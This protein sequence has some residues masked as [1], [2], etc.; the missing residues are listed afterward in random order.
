M[1]ARG[2]MTLGPCFVS[3][4]Q[5]P[6]GGKMAGKKKAAPVVTDPKA[7]QDLEHVVAGNPEAP[8]V[9][10]EEEAKDPMY[11]KVRI[12]VP[13]E[14]KIGRKV[15]PVGTHVVERHQLETILEMVNKKQR[16]NLAIFTGG[17]YLVEKMVD[18]ALRVSQVEELNS[19]TLI[20]V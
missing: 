2:V 12:T 18:G 5:L 3:N 4:K 16:A 11:D 20:G 15:L 1:R 17:N 13:V 8:E 10:V 6:K 14:V 9:Q 7:D 19:K